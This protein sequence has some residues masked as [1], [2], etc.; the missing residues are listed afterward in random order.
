ML[1]PIIF[2]QENIHQ[3]TR[4]KKMLAKLLVKNCTNS[5]TRTVTKLVSKARHEPNLFQSEGIKF[6]ILHA[7]FPQGAVLCIEQHYCGQQALPLSG[8]ESLSASFTITR[9]RP[10]AGRVLKC[11]L[12]FFFP[13]C[14][15]ALRTLI[16]SQPGDT[17]FEIT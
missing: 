8:F 1:Q 5:N 11:R 13:C 14:D 7:I 2:C 16:G 4:I 9:P 15:F 12:F 17:S 6:L 3:Q 10:K